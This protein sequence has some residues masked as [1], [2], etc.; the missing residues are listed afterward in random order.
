MSTI[1]QVEAQMKAR[2]TSFAGLNAVVKFDFGS[3]GAIFVNGKTM[4]P[5]ISQ[6]GTDPDTTL[7][8]SLDDFI[9][10]SEGKLAPTMA[11]MTGKLKVSGNMGVAMKLSSM[12]ED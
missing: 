2:A 9:K 8:I 3:M 6:Q 10:L 1:D 12:L 11:F 7:A 5:S 4:P